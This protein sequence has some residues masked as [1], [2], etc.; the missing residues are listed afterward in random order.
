MDGAHVPEASIDEDGDPCTAE[1]HVS[2]APRGNRERGVHP[3]AETQGMN[4][5]TDEQLRDRAPPG[6]SAET[7]PSGFVPRLRRHLTPR[8]MP[9]VP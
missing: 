9:R 4:C 8:G 2:P 6:L 1:E 7:F 3:V 5:P